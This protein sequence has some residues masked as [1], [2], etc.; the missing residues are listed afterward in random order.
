MYPSRS[1]T[2]V[3]F[4][5]SLC[6]FAIFG[7]AHSTERSPLTYL[8]LVDAPVVH[9]PSHRVHALSHF[10]LTFDL[11]ASQQ[12]I[13]LTLKPNHDVIAEGAT[14]QYLAADGSVRS[15]ELMDR[16]EYR[17]FKGQAWVQHHEGA[18]WTN[19][20]W[21]R[22]MV[23]QDGEEP[24]FEGAF[25]VDGDH[26]H[27]QT[28]T[29][30][31]DTKHVLDPVLEESE[32]EFM[33]VWRDSDIS[34]GFTED[35]EGLLHG[36]L[37]RAVSDEHSCSADALSFNADLQHPVFRA[38]LKPREDFGSLS[39]K[40]LFGRQIDGTTSGN[41][42]G[43]NLTTTIGSTSG[44][45]T[46]RKVALVG[47]ATDCTYTAALG[48]A[49]AARQNVISVIN[50]A[51]VQYEDSFNITLGLA[52]LTIS[53]AAC[54]ATASSSAPWNIG[55][56]DSVTIQDR[57]NLF[58]AWRG[59]RGDSNAYWTLLSTCATGS[60]VGLAWLG[61]ACVTTSTT[62]SSS[63]GNE[64][65][66]GANVVVRTSTEWQVVAHETGHTFGAVHDCTSTTCAD[67]TTVAS[68]QCCPLSASACDAGGA[69]IMNPST[70][71]GITKFSACSIGNICTAIGRNSVKTSC[72]SANKDVTTI[73]GSQCGNG[74][75]ES[76]EDCDCGGTSGCGS[77]SCCNPT[78]CKFTTN[79][80]CDPSNEDCCTSSCQ[81]AS[82]GTICRASTG[83][84][85]PQEVCSGTAAVCPTDATAPDG[86]SCG[87]S[88]QSLSCASGQCTSRD[89]QCKTL[90]G[91]YTQGN[92]TYA[93]SSSGC[94]ISCASPE[95]GANVCYS[96]QQNFVDGTS[97]QGG[98]KCSN[99]ACTG[100]SVGKEITSWIHDNKTL[101]IALA[102]VIG[103]LFI[104]AVLSCCWSRYRRRNAV[105]KP[106]RPPPG[107][108]GAPLSSRGYSG[109]PPGGPPPQMSSRNLGQGQGGGWQPNGRWS[110][111]PPNQPPP[112]Y[113][114]PSVR[115]A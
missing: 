69:F 59:Q 97:C 88:S 66:S 2:A 12:R 28:R 15:T 51:S 34:T 110:G 100:S 81:Y 11:H 16:A 39:T 31:M 89:L 92:D 93:C 115:Y 18:E 101:V 44:C 48:N 24:I 102:S 5:V 7:D 111:P 47:V 56:S 73:S 108:R 113:S 98:G 43:V 29:H 25:R 46:T 9:T 30:Y 19:V 72:L 78:T 82:S 50:S 75:V 85:D 104:L 64:T 35:A 13:K 55:C 26:H 32:K 22:I 80:V 45:P 83:V 37:K 54:P 8:T 107:W 71:S 68:Q 36:E 27:I 79:S 112:V 58:S 61:Q 60:A 87:N 103:G 95:F 84:C 77:N 91:S 41:S 20:G 38:M 52:N 90:M 57:L 40:S 4:W 76:G 10:D 53:D 49:T 96:M 23:H 109:P 63:S 94:Q 74:I 67:G 70:G 6:C 17:V 42:A 99:G 86:T 33:V 106:L 21:A 114:G 3:F 1:L 105:R 62:A 14:I 65:V